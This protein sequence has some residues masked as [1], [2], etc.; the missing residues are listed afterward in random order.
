MNWYVKRFGQA[1]ITFWVVVTISFVLTRS[2]P[3][4][5]VDL[6]VERMG[7]G[8]S[9]PREQLRED[10]VERLMLDPTD[11]MYEQ[12]FEYMVNLFQ[13]NM[14]VSVSVRPLVPVTEVL[15]NSLPWTLLVMSMAVFGMFAISLS[16]GALMAYKEQSR[17]DYGNTAL[18]IVTSS[19]PYYV[20]G[21]L[22]IKLAGYNYIPEALGLA[23]NGL[24]GGPLNAFLD[25]FPA[26]NKTPDGVTAGL[27]LPFI[28]GALRHA[29]LP[30]L[31]WILFAYGAMAIAMRGNSIQTLGEDYVRVAELRGLPGRRIALRYVGRNAVLPL[32]TSL[33]ITIGAMLGAS[34]VLEQIFGYVGVGYF[35]LEA[36]NQKDTPLLMGVFMV[37][38]FALVTAVLIADLT[39][40]FIDPRIT[41]G[42]EGE[43]Y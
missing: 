24:I 13:G 26:Q 39:Y 6:L 42:D 23:P 7:R 4:S 29:F 1:L 37:I 5:T 14:G 22:L 2:L 38:A 41:T 15:A 31:S 8:N 16:L 40:G 32:Y 35:L 43:A 12:Y 11:P 34:V 30:A 17:F 19:V 33:L 28:F 25:L 10:A 21:L 27:N 9:V 3:Y 18:A 36:I 20:T